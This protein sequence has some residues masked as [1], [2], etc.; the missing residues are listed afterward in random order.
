MRVPSRA[1]SAKGRY[2]GAANVREPTFSTG[3]GRVR[4]R[5]RRRKPCTSRCEEVEGELSP[6]I[7]KGTVVRDRAGEEVGVVDDLRF[8]PANGQLQGFVMRAGGTI[9]RFFGGGETREIDRS[10]V[11]RVGDGNV[12][13]RLG[14]EEITRS[15]H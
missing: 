9:Q 2:C 12:Y 3:D 8:D 11:E 10:D 6:A 5:A 14:K 1:L 7:D 4:A 13:L 15:A